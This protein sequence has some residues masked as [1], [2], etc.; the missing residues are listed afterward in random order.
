MARDLRV[1][2]KLSW[3]IFFNPSGR[4]I[5]VILEFLKQLLPI[6]KSVDGSETDDIDEWLKHPSHNSVIPDWI[7]Y[8]SISLL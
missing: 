8:T 7:E 4:L 6:V 1:E 2:G 5:V 3:P